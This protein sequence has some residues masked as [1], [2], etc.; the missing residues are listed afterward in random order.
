MATDKRMEDLDISELLGNNFGDYTKEVLLDRAI[1]DLRDGLKPVQRRI[2]YEMFH[3]GWTSNKPTIKT[4]KIIGDVMGS[5]HAHGDSGIQ[6]A[7]GNM[8][9]DW[10]RNLPE[11]YMHGNN[12]NIDGDAPAAPRYTE[13]KLT[14]YAEEFTDGLNKDGVVKWIPTY[15]DSSKE[16]TVLPAKLPNILIN[17]GSGIGSAYSSDMLPHNVTEVLN[18]CIAVLKDEAISMDDLLEIIPA[19]DFPT[20][21]VIV[22][23]KNN[24]KVYLSGKG[25]FKT[26][27]EFTVETK[28]NKKIIKFTSIPFGVKK[29]DLKHSFDDI[30]SNKKIDGVKDIVDKSD[31]HGIDIEVECAKDADI[32]VVLGY[33]FKKT[34]MMVNVQMNNVVVADRKPQLLSLKQIILKFNKFRVETTKRIYEADKATLEGEMHILEGFVKFAKDMDKFVALIRESTGKQDAIDKMVA[35]GFSET[36]ASTIVVVP[37]YR[38]AKVSMDEYQAKLNDKQKVYDAIVKVLSS[39]AMVKKAVLRSY[40]ELLKRYKSDRKTGIK[41]EDESWDVA[42]VDL[43][44]EEDVMVSVTKHGY[45]KRSSVRSYS[46]T[47]TEDSDA[48]DLLDDDEIVF[49]GLGNTKGGL[50]ILTNKLKYLYIPIHKID[51]AK[52]KDMGKNIAVLGAELDSDEFVQQALTVDDS[53]M[54]ESILMVKSDGNVRR[55]FVE[56]FVQTQQVYKAREL[57]TGDYKGVNLVGA[58]L[59]PKDHEGYVGYKDS[60]G[61]VMYSKTDDI[62]TTSAIRAKGMRGVGVNKGDFVVE[63]DYSEQEYPIYVKYAFLKE[64][65]RKGFKFKEIDKRDPEEYEAKKAVYDEYLATIKPEDDDVKAESSDDITAEG[66]DVKQQVSEDFV[67]KDDDVSA[68]R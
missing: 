56:N 12:G 19:P 65:A 1:P 26:R 4:A 61:R 10:K 63:S 46:A 43:I 52:W 35:E 30:V 41:M 42:K 22:D 21:G 34:N 37:V 3:K 28:G 9:Q 18:A 14:K 53:N 60:I 27:G 23:A 11:I 15:D 49:K 36:Q 66:D 6:T 45:I 50:I 16:P 59:I 13:S 54:Q 64:R 38:L 29:N 57:Y 25:S 40:K 31:R 33:L 32:N 47:S 8:S 55:T 44:K 7:I 24:K 67:P 48:F 58:Y 20:G 2:I 62:S 51:D 68:E 5:L 17:G 39:E